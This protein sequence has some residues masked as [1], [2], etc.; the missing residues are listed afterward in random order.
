VPS[1]RV[2]SRLSM[3]LPDRILTAI[4]KLNV[5]LYRASRGRLMNKVGR[6]PVL[7]LTT[8]GRRSG[9]RRTAPVVYLA[10]G[11]RLIVIGSNAGNER[12]PAW[13][14][15]LRANPDAQVETGGNRRAVR[16]RVTAGEERAELWRRCNEQ[17]A[18]FE[19]Y[20]ARTS[21]DIP[22]FVLERPERRPSEPGPPKT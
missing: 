21:R 9:Q 7:L 1:D 22:V 5:P 20:K 19:D 11:E 13:A 6:A 17:Y 2:Y 16:A 4:G 15:N 3:A 14:L 8:T 18:G 10:D 12:T